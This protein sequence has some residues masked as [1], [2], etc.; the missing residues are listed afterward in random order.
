VG[1]ENNWKSVTAGGYHTV[2]LRTDGTLW[3]WGYNS[4]GQLGLG[5]F[6]PSSYHREKSPQKVGQEN[7]WKSVTAGGYHTGAIKTDGT[8][9]MW[10]HNYYGQLG[11]GQ[12]YHKNYIQPVVELGN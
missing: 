1:Q 6:S 7:N 8:L 11:N 2:A 5:H 4:Y 10:G 12:I 3:T 9:W